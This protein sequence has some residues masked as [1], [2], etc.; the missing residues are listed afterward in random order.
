[1]GNVKT[2]KL[3]ISWSLSVFAFKANRGQIPLKKIKWKFF[4]NFFTQIIM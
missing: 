4:M 1:M 3:W 2:K